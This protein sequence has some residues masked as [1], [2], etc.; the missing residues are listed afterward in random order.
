ME[1]ISSILIFCLF[2]C[3]L[4]KLSAQDSISLK[5]VKIHLNK[6]MEDKIGYTQAIKVG[7]TVYVSG[8]VGWGTWDKALGIAYEGLVETLKACNANFSDVV[9][10]NIYTLSLDSLKKYSTIRSKYY[11]TDYPTGSWVEVK[12]LFDPGIL[13]EIELELMVIDKK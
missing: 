1:R 10:E 13:V 9:K 2:C 11:G 6:E 8:T 5:K 7:N 3:F 12:Q 4:A